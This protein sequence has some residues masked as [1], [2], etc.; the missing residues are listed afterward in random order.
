MQGAAGR[1]PRSEERAMSR[2]ACVPAT[3]VSRRS[4]LCLLA[5]CSFVPVIDTQSAE[6]PSVLF[7]CPHGAAKSVLASAYFKAVAAERGLR[8][9]VD[10]AGTEPD[11]EIA[12]KVHEHLRQQGLEPSS[13]PRRGTS[14]DVEQ[15]DVGIS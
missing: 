5:F 10:F 13:L 12:P 6:P 8:V 1:C 14:A 9:R 2:Q 15:G 4:A 3:D 7:L 11:A